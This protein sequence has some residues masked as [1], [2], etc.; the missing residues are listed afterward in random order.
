MTE[1]E[2]KTKWCCGPPAIV[3]VIV[4]HAAGD[5]SKE[6]LKC[7]ASACMA[8]RVAKIKTEVEQG[9]DTFAHS[10]TTTVGYCGLASRP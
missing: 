6:P 2:A 8:W 10:W 3:A 5:T 9:G 7:L 4:N 1:D